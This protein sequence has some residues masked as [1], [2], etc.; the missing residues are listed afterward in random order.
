MKTQEIFADLAETSRAAELRR[1]AGIFSGGKEEAVAARVKR[2][3]SRWEAD[4]TQPSYPAGLKRCL[5]AIGLGLSASGAKKQSS[6]LQI[7]LTLFEGSATATVDSFVERVTAALAA[8]PN[9]APRTNRTQAADHT[10]ANDLA[11]ELARAALDAEAF[12]KVVDRLRDSKRVSTPTL[13]A[14]ANRFLGN[15]K[16]YTGRKPAIDD[17]MNRQKQDVRSHARGRALDRIGV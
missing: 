5:A 15:S 4:P 7:I 17:I 12:A 11:N 3:L 10:L 9:T 14:A 1:F 2:V 16:N 6:D 8:P 13:A